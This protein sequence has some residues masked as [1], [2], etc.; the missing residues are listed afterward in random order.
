MTVVASTTFVAWSQVDGL[1]ASGAIELHGDPSKAD[2]H[3]AAWVVSGMK[4]T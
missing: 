3:I 2:A 4:L 1:E